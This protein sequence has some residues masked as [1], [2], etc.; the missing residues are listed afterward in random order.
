MYYHDVVY[1][2]KISGTYLIIALTGGLFYN[3]IP[4]CISGEHSVAMLYNKIRKYY[5]CIL[6]VGLCFCML[7]Y[8]RIPLCNE[9]CMMNNFLS[10][11]FP[12]ILR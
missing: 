10:F 1:I 7:L 8:R 12:V 6:L 5:V 2:I 3:F 4:D 11:L 9:G